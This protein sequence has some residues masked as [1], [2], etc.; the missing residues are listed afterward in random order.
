MTNGG[1]TTNEAKECAQEI[2]ELP[3]DPLCPLC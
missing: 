3:C 2:A 1:L